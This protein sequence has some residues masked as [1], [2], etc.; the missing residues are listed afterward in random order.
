MGDADNARNDPR[1][2]AG[3]SFRQETYLAGAQLLGMKV[4]SF[5]RLVIRKG[6]RRT[7]GND[8]RARVAIPISEVDQRHEHHTPDDPNPP[9]RGSAPGVTGGAGSGAIPAELQALDALADA[10]RQER[11]R[12]EVAEAAVARAEGEEAGLQDAIRLAEDSAREARHREAVAVAERDAVRIDFQNA[13]GR[14]QRAEVEAAVHQQAAEQAEAR[15]AETASLMRQVVG[16]FEAT[17]RERVQAQVQ[18]TNLRQ[19]LERAEAERDGARAEGAVLRETVAQEAARA[20]AARKSAEAARR[21]QQAAEI[22]LDIARDEIA[23]LI[24]G[25]RLRQAWS[26]FR[27]R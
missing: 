9:E 21:A 23:A 4:D 26:A 20:D 17:H 8:G 1:G 10:L 12:R 15:E 7:R 11:G 24:R 13:I 18:A 14:A 2:S 19:H 25:G 3:G 22:A 16:Q 6:W 27:R 5:R